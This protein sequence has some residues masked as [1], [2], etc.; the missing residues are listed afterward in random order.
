MSGAPGGCTVSVVVPVRDCELYV[1]EALD[2]ILG[3]SASPAEV[4]VVDDG[5]VDGTPAVLDRFGDAIRVLRRDPPGGPAVAINA[6]V[7]ESSQPL[8]A[9]LDADDLWERESLACRLAR[10]GAPDAPDAVFGQMTQ[11]VSP[12][13]GPGAVAR[14]RFDPGPARADLFQ[15]ML[16]RRDAFARVGPLDIT[17]PSASNIDWV[18]RARV[19]GLSMVHIDDV[20]GHRRLHRSNMGVT[21]GAAKLKTLTEVVRAHH[22]RTRGD[23]ADKDDT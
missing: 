3:Q 13:L 2:S 22:A 17:L 18:S 9:F 5:S 21:L 14:Y 6:G 7:A 8:L 11:F 23:H 10:I 12:D 1:R 16:I 15:T 20:V 4:I 19:T